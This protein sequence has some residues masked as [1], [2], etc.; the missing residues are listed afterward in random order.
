[1]YT[2][3][4]AYTQTTCTYMYLMTLLSSQ[5]AEK[6]RKVLLEI[7]AKA[8]AVESTGQA[9]AE[10]QVLLHVLVLLHILV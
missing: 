3:T 10:A 4:T 2:H 1:M 8:A 7:Q 9:K 6:A 5:E